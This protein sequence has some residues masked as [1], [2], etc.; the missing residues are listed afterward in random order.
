VRWKCAQARLK[1][2]SVDQ[3]T[4]TDI[5]PMVQRQ[6]MPAHATHDAQPGSMMLS[7]R[8]KRDAQRAR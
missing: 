8:Y 2:F 5:E 3:L 7:E 4:L 1:F 6:R